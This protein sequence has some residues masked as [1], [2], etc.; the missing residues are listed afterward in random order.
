M[1]REVVCRRKDG[2]I[3]PA[4]LAVSQVNHLGLFTGILRDISSLKEMQR[5]ILEIASEEQRRIGFELHDGTQQELTGLSLY[6]NALQET[7]QTAIELDAPDSSL[8]QFNQ[9]DF[10]RLKHTASLLTKRIAETNE[11]VR[12]LAH[13]IMPV[14]IDAEG[15]RSALMELVASINAT[16]EVRCEFEQVGEISIR[17]NTTATHLYRI[18]Q[19]AVT[20]ALRHGSADYIKILLVHQDNR[21]VLEISD[22]GS[23]FQ[24]SPT[25]VAARSRAGMGMRTMKYRASLIGGRLQVQRARQGGTLIH[26]ELLRDGETYD[27]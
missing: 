18:A 24:S 13:G 21:I 3:F 1:G 17:D 4:D 11:H 5:H 27:G 15:L 26:C 16:K 6:A 2:T 12:D 22:N 7:I 8:V 9:M 10:E 20:N 23:G 19:E 25:D 14:Q